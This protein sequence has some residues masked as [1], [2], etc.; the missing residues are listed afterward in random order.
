MW[1]SKDWQRK[2]YSVSDKPNPMISIVDDDE[3]IREATEA[4]MRSLGL[5]ARTFPLAVDFLASPDIRSTA[6]LVAD[7]NMPRMTGVEL[8]RHLVGLGYHIPTIL[9]TA[10]PDEEVRARALA[11]GVLCFLTKPFDEED[12]LKC[13]RLALDGK[14][15]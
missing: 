4:Q 2:G 3:S 11:E 14:A 7:V 6:C 9:I 1:Y 5:N 8:H 10:Y 12:L 15:G 13:V